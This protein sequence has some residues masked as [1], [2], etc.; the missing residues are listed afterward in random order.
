MTAY[1]ISDI[2]FTFHTET[3]RIKSNN[4]FQERQIKSAYQARHFQR[5]AQ[6][7]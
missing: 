2:D 3:E 7:I 1:K 4:N 6:N 5:T